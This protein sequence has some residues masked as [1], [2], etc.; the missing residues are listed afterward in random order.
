[1][2]ITK[3]DICGKIKRREESN[4][5]GGWLHGLSNMGHFDLCGKCGDGLEKLLEKYFTSRKKYGR[6]RVSKTI[7]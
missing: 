5:L 2:L 7:R 1:M 4:W 3:C 6:K